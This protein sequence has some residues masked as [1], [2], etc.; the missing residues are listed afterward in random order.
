M[1]KILFVILFS[2]IFI[3]LIAQEARKDTVAVLILQRMSDV[4]GDLTSVSF[5]VATSIDVDNYEYGVTKQYGSDQ[6]YMVGPN[7]MLVHAFGYKGHRGF[8]YNGETTTYYS[9]DENNY[10]IIPSPKNIITT[11]DSIHK[12][13][14]YRFPGCRF[15][16]PNFYRRYP[17]KL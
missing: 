8:W 7:K 2:G 13:L 4:I 5:D 6:V 3:N 12:Y 11:I 17:G 14:W 10:A 9:F 15:L 1:K 16:L